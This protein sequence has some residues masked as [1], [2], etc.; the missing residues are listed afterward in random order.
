MRTEVAEAGLS[1]TS[2]AGRPGVTPAAASAR[3]SPWSAARMAC[4]T[5]VPSMSLAGKVHRARLAD[6]DDLDLSRVLEVAFDLAGDLLGELARLAVVDRGGRDDDPH[7]PPRLDGKHLLHAR[8]RPP[9][10]PDLG[11]PFTVRFKPP[12]PRPPPHAHNAP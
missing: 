2:T 11:E 5:A 3:S 9:H 7:L 4:P 12:P 6:D 8:K 10:L 1:P